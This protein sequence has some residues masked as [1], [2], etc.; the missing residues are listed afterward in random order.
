MAQCDGPQNKGMKQTTPAQAME[1]RSLSPVFCGLEL[2]LPATATRLAADND[3]WRG[4]PAVTREQLTERCGCVSRRLQFG[5]HLWQAPR[6]LAGEHPSV[7]RG[8]RV[9]HDVPCLARLPS[10]DGAK[11]ALGT[12]W[13]ATAAA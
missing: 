3:V 9:R 5:C 4:W 2:A 6:H 8:L 1:L 7:I 11:R 12:Q 10:I 13:L